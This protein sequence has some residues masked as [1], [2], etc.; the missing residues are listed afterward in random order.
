MVVLVIIGQSFGSSF[1]D[2]CMCPAALCKWLV[3]MTSDGL[4]S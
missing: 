1:I 4:G 3:Y 2:I